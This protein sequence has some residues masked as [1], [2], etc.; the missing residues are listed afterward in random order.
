MWSTLLGNSS[1]SYGISQKKPNQ[2]TS[3]G[4][5]QKVS[6][7]FTRADGTNKHYNSTVMLDLC[8]HLIR[9]K[10]VDSI[11]W[12]RSDE[13]R[14]ADAPK[15]IERTDS[16]LFVQES[17]SVA[18]PLSRGE[19]T[20]SD[21]QKIQIKYLNNAT[22]LKLLLVNFH[23]IQRTT[24]SNVPI[25]GLII[26]DA[27][28]I[29]STAVLDNFLEI[30]ALGLEAV[31]SSGGETGISFFALSLSL[32]KREASTSR[33]ASFFSTRI[34]QIDEPN[35]CRLKIVPHGSLFPINE[36]KS[37]LIRP[38]SSQLSSASGKFDVSF[39]WT[40]DE[41]VSVE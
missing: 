13:M 19:D 18:N 6:L 36:S 40:P 30:S 24:T 25:T 22:E 23:L 1:T 8:L 5:E 17:K 12:I 10:K 15:L 34:E 39:M 41:M 35:F 28:I 32:P 2:I 7:L 4:I 3:K 33:L 38:I 21:L 16:E 37:V 31:Q 9:E 29:C 14:F 27:E 11:L 26:D 20:E